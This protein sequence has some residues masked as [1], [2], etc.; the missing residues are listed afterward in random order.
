VDEMIAALEQ[1]KR[2]GASGLATGWTVQHDPQTP[3]IQ[4]LVVTEDETSVEIAGG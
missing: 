3:G 2:A 4:T 1:A